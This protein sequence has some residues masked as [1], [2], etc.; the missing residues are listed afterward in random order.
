MIELIQFPW[1]PFCLVQRRILEYSGTPFRVIDIPNGERS[2][3]WQITKQ[4]Y[5]QVPVLRSGKTV[6]F[7]TGEN[8]QVIAKYLD[9][10][11]KLDLF[12]QRWSG[13]RGVTCGRQT[14]ER[15]AFD[16]VPGE[17]K[18]ILGDHG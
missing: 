12:P 8:S 1:S 2:L 7:D 10:K 5:F 15:P 11:L 14:V 6:I 17:R 9:S 4:R 13:I 3:V 16:F 18:S